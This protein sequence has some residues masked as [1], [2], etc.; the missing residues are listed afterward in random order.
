ME[1]YR[2]Q[3]LAARRL[4]SALGLKLRD[5]ALL[6]QALVHRSFLNEQG[7][8]LADSYERL[9][10][11]GDA[12]LGLTVSAEL[13]RRYPL[14]DEGEL[15]KLR[16]SLV[17]GASLARVARRLGLGEFLLLGRG[18]AASGGRGRDSLLAAAFEAVVAAVF[19]D[20]GYS[21]A[22]RFILR[23]MAEDLEEFS[24]QGAPPENPKSR[25]Q[26]YLQGL[27]RPTPR[28]RLVSSQGPDHRPL[29]TVEVLVED[30][31]VGAGQGGSRADAERCAAQDALSRLLPDFSRT[32]F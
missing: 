22:S 10:Y 25:L 2:E 5:P 16:A 17:C 19:L 29:F 12:V 7:G 14:L 30:E 20:Q 28:Y 24:P 26:E 18:E 23:T 8:P 3:P 4:E 6:Q 27:G 32:S 9:E 21:R 11:L 31:A 13:F 1:F 15:T